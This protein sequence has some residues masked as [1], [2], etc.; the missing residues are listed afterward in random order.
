MDRVLRTQNICLFVELEE[1]KLFLFVNVNSKNHIFYM[2]SVGHFYLSVWSYYGY[3]APAI[4]SF[5]SSVLNE[6][7]S[8]RVSTHVYFYLHTFTY[9]F[10]LPGTPSLF[11][12][13][14]NPVVS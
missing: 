3:G 1:T 8:C 13:P 6:V 2:H 11:K 5:L 7:D 10:F 4:V 12:S 14:P 9:A